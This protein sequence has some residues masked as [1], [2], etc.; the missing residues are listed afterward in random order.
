MVGVEVKD[1]NEAELESEPEEFNDD[2]KQEV[3]LEDH[4]AGDGVFPEGGVDA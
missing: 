4:F 2:P 3:A 1:A